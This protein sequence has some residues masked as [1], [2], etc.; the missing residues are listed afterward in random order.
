MTWGQVPVTA[1]DQK[2]K[3]VSTSIN[4]RYYF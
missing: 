2:L 4:L 3:V 1:L